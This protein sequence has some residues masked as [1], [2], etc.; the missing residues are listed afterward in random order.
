M[1][2]L[3]GRW[4]TTANVSVAPVA[5][6][7]PDKARQWEPSIDSLRERLPIVSLGD[8]DPAARRGPAYWLRCVVAGTVDARRRPDGHPDRLPAGC[9]PR[10]PAG[11]RG[12]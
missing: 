5:L 6:L 1:L 10:R 8:Y 11:G 7:W 2:A 12:R 9:R 3:D 4:S